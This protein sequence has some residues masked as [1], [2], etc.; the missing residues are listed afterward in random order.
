ML[1]LGGP[2]VRA[3]RGAA[4]R[5]GRP[6]DRR[7]ARRRP[8][9]SSPRSSWWERTSAAAD[10]AARPLLAAEL[11]VREPRDA[12][13]STPGSRRSRSSSCC[14]CSSSPATRRCRV[15]LALAPDHGRHVR[16]LA[17]RRPALDAARPA[18]LHGR[19]AARSRP[20]ALVALVRLKPGFD[21]WTELLPPLLV[22]SV[23]LSMIVAPLTATVLADADESDAGIASGVN[24]A[25]ARVAGLLGIA[26]VGASVAG[27]SNNARHVGLPARDVDHRRPR[28]RGRR[29]RPRRNPEQRDDR[30]RRDR[31]R[32][33]DEALRRPRRGS[34]RRPVARDPG[35]RVLRA[36]RPV[37]RRQDDGAEDGQPADPVRLGRDPDRRPEHRDAAAD[38]A[39]P[40]DRLRD[41]AG[42]PLPAHDDRREHRHRAAAARL[43][44]G[45]GR[46]RAPSSCSSS[47]GSRRPTRSAT[48]RSS[49]AG[50]ASA[51]GS[52]ARSPPTRRSS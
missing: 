42:R 44:Q 48:R 41:P 21:Y 52:R 17:A 33:R 39:A 26:V 38:R 11:L 46:G 22:F 31:L 14:S 7:A 3:D 4:P 32:P 50:S 45:S 19:R 2:G 49:P 1:G 34:G 37:G 27:S 30:R 5:L 51:S 23:G 24:N 40:R 10:A 6:A 9:R 36:R 18:P 13:P 29:H 15:G 35:R 47:S 8:R 43:G 28:R 16:P 20:P 12:R 25:V